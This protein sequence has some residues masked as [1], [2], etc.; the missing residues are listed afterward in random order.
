MYNGER[1]IEDTLEMW[2]TFGNST[3]QYSE[4]GNVNAEGQS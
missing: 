4:Q 3:L 1:S 2:E